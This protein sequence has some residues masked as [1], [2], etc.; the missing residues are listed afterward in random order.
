MNEVF[1]DEE[2]CFAHKN[3]EVIRWR[4]EKLAPRNFEFLTF[5]KYR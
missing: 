2:K 1:A 5:L 3:R 4:V